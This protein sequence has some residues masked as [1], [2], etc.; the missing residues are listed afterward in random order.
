MENTT[1]A[2]RA[3]EAHGRGEKPRSRDG[4]DGI[5]VLRKTARPQLSFL[6]GAVGILL[7]V[8]ALC[9]YRAPRRGISH[10]DDDIA[11]VIWIAVAVQ[12]LAASI[13]GIVLGTLAAGGRDARRCVWSAFGRMMGLIAIVIL[14]VAVWAAGNRYDL[15]H[16]LLF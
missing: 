13:V 3:G 9:T 4:D 16:F 6:F 14:A 11:M 2:A 1:P 5:H 10:L 8:I 12:S 7:A 15:F